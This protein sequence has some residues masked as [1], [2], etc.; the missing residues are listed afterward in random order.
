MTELERRRKIDMIKA[1]DASYEEKQKALAKLEDI[2]SVDKARIQFEESKADA[3][4]EL[5]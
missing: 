4:E 1:L 3:I 5:D 2:S